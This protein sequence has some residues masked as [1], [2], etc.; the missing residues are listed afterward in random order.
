[1]LQKLG[2]LHWE[3][4]YEDLV[5]GDLRQFS[6]RQAESYT[7]QSLQEAHSNAPIVLFQLAK[8]LNAAAQYPD[9]LRSL[10]QAMDAG[11]S[12]SRA[13]PYLAEIAYNLRRYDLVHQVLFEMKG[14]AVTPRLR[15][16]VDLWSQVNNQ[17]GRVK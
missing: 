7:R 1:L 11:L 2:E 13:K 5:H 9:A 6:L 8:I 16:L 3:L 17:K 4:V 15:P 14:A 10:Q 12:K